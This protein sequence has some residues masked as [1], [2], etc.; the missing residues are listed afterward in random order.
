VRTVG[1]DQVRNVRFPSLPEGL[2]T[3]P[4]LV[5]KVNAEKAGPKQGDISYLTNGMT[6]AAE[7]VAVVNEDDDAST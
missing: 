6:W 3:R 2:I 5:W 4:T 1:L 7:Y